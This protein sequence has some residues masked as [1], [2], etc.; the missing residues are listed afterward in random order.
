MDCVG[1]LILTA[2]DFDMDV[3]DMTG[4]GRQ[5]QGEAF[6]N[7]LK[8]HLV[9]CEQKPKSGRVAV[10]RDENFPCH[11]GF[12]VERKNQFYLLHS[13]AHRRKVVEEV[14]TRDWSTKLRLFMDFPEVED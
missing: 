8:K 1:L 7:Q 4:Y 6:V 2:K 13:S 10:F 12:I 3:E 9:V 5:A 14:W 11:C